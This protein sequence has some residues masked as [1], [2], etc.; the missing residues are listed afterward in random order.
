ME[1]LTTLGAGFAEHWQVW[2]VAVVL[3]VAAVI[4]GYQLKVPNWLTYPM[5]I[6]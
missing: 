5:I 3:V 2:L 1:F 4:D 6:G